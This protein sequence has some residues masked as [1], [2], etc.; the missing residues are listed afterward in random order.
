MCLIEI[1]FLS[2]QVEIDVGS[3]DPIA[4]MV[5]GMQEHHAVDAPTDP[6][7]DPGIRRYLQFGQGLLYAIAEIQRGK[8]PNSNSFFQITPFRHIDGQHG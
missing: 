1:R 2:T 3:C 5:Q 4:E 8:S 7:E 6:E